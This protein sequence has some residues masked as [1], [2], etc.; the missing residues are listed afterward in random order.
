MRELVA[1]EQAGT[2]TGRQIRS[3]AP[4]TH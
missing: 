1:T 2:K 3:I 4:R